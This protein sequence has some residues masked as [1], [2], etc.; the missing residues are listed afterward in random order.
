MES[1][2]M[3]GTLIGRRDN[4]VIARATAEKNCGR[5]RTAV[6]DVTALQCRRNRNAIEKT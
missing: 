1:L 2:P 5:C 4:S 6:I 3:H